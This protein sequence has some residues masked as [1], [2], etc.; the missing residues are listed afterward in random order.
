[1][2]AYFATGPECVLPKAIKCF[3]QGAWNSVPGSQVVRQRI[4]IPPYAG[5]TPA[6]AT[7]AGAVRG[8]DT[9]D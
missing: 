1:M 7:I 2:T 3:T 6:R 5:S 9:R 8:S 4:L